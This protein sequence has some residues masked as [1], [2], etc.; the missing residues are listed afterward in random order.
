MNRQ[1]FGADK[2][3]SYTRCLSNGFVK[4]D[5]TH[6][7]IECL[8]KIVQRRQDTVILLCTRL[9]QHDVF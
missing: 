4:L 2:R 7:R 9:L 3:E 5:F 6:I 1:I 8:L